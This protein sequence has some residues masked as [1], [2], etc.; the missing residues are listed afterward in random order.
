MRAPLVYSRKTAL[1]S[2]ACGIIIVMH[3]DKAHCENR[4][5]RDEKQGTSISSLLAPNARPSFRTSRG[6]AAPLGAIPL[7]DSVNFV[8]MCRHGIAAHLVIQPLDS[9]DILAEIP[10]DPHLHR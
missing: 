5:T 10:L 4:G 1:F 2:P 7:G 8:L 9:D 3:A 6:R